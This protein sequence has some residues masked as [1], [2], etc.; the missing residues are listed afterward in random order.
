MTSSQATEILLEEVNTAKTRISR[1]YR[2]VKGVFLM[3]SHE[4]DEK[5][6]RASSAQFESM[7]QSLTARQFLEMI[8]DSLT[9]EGLSPLLVG[10]NPYVFYE[11]LLNMT[12]VQLS[13]LKRESSTEPLQH[14]IL[15]FIHF[16]EQYEQTDEIQIYAL[17][18]QIEA[19]PLNLL[20][21][22]DIQ[23][24]IEQ[25]EACL[26]KCQE[27]ELAIDRALELVWNAKRGDLLEKLSLIKERLQRQRVMRLGQA[28]PSTGI[29]QLL[30]QKL[31]RVYQ[32][33]LTG[34]LQDSDPSFD[35]LALL[36]IWYLQ[37]YWDVGLLPAIKQWGELAA[38]P[39]EKLEQRD[40]LLEEVTKNLQK[41]NLE[42][43]GDLKRAGIFS[44]P[45]LIDYVQEHI[46]KMIAP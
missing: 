28:S 36:S 35:G 12:P 7:A 37:D 31:S 11:T 43:V 5:S 40:H 17:E 14:Q 18:Q 13:V 20:R 45:M 39:G 32:S 38:K 9:P 25:I 22:Q 46:L 21:N 24:L 29:Y 4:S 34:P 10:L 15:L 1:K 27:R 41:L 16:C 30:N 23:D 8:T 2:V 44:K 6:F 42:T 3:S 33:D 19:L 26:L